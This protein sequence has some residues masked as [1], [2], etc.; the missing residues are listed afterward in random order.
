MTSQSRLLSK[1]NVF[2]SSEIVEFFLQYCIVHQPTQQ[3]IVKRKK[4]KEEKK[5]NDESY[6]RKDVTF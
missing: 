5:K 2:Y 3:K 1:N 6:T 4:S